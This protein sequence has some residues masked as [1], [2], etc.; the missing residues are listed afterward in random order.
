M[1]CRRSHKSAGLIAAAAIAAVVG[2]GAGAAHATPLTGAQFNFGKNTGNFSGTGALGETIVPLAVGNGNFSN[3]SFALG[4]GIS[5]VINSPAFNGTGAGTAAAGT[6]FANY[7]FGTLSPNTLTFEGL[8]AGDTY[9]VAGYA[10]TPDTFTVGT[11]SV[12]ATGAYTPGSPF[13]GAYT[14]GVNYATLNGTADS[15]G[16]LVLSVAPATGHT[17]FRIA[18]VG[19]AAVS[20]PEPASITMMLGGAAGLMLLARRKRLFA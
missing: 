4:G 20:T 14:L 15:S 3:V 2:A 8:T 11:N 1:G 13:V 17:N 12:T 10:Q 5:L 9:E 18:G 16:D 19:I 6:I 7:A